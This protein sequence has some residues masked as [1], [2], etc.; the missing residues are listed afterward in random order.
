MK[1]ILYK[2]SESTQEPSLYYLSGI[3]NSEPQFSRYSADA[4]KYSLLYAIYLSFRFN[5]TWIN[6]KYIQKR[7]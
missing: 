1:Y 7:K 6:E 3:Y 5:L 2:Y 4:R